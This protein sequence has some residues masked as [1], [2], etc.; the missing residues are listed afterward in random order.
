MATTKDEV[1]HPCTSVRSLLDGRLLS[2]LLSSF[3]N[4]PKAI[5]SGSFQ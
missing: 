4:S 1:A 2:L 5:E 3:A